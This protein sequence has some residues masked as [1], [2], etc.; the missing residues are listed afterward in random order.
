MPLRL[1]A[2]PRPP[3]WTFDPRTEVPDESHL[4]SPQRIASDM[5]GAPIPLDQ[6]SIQE[7][8]DCADWRL[9]RCEPNL[10]FFAGASPEG[11]A[12]DGVSQ[13]RCLDTGLIPSSRKQLLN[14]CRGE[15]TFE[16]RILADPVRA[17]GPVSTMKERLSAPVGVRGD[18]AIF[19]PTCQRGRRSSR[20]AGRYADP[21][22]APGHERVARLTARRRMPLRRGI[23]T[24]SFPAVDGP[25]IGEVTGLWDVAQNHTQLETGAKASYLDGPSP[26]R[27]PCGW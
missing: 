22:C 2:V 12:V 8:N 19:F 18:P 1:P 21:V 11:D 3:G 14:W 5:I 6:K 17:S 26:S 10:C 27:V 24:L 23:P 25:A 4:T 9:F 7:L 15:V 20:R 13:F 16:R